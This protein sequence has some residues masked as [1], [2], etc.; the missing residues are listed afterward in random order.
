MPFSDEDLMRY[1]DEI[2]L[3]NDSLRAAKEITKPQMTIGADSLESKLRPIADKPKFKN[4]SFGVVIFK[5]DP[6]DK[7]KLKA[8]KV[9]FYKEDVAWQTD[10]TGKLAILLAGV[11]LRED[12]NAVLKAGDGLD[13]ASCDK[14]FSVIWKRMGNESYVT[15]IR[16]ED[17]PRISTIFKFTDRKADFFGAPGTD[18]EMWVDKLGNDE[19][20][21]NGIPVSQGEEL[22]FYDR[23]RL[24]G[25]F[26]NNV[27]SSACMSEIGIPY[28]VAVQKALGLYRPE[29]G[30]HLKIGGPFQGGNRVGRRVT[31]DGPYL[32]RD[33]I[34]EKHYKFN[35]PNYPVC[36]RQKD[37]VCESH[38]NSVQPGSVSA[39]LAFMI[40][41][42]EDTLVSKEACN[43]IR[44]CITNY[45]AIDNSYQWGIGDPILKRVPKPKEWYCKTG[46]IANSPSCSFSYSWIEEGII[47]LRSGVVA[48]GVWEG[49]D[50]DRMGDLG[51]EIYQAIK[52]EGI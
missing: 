48:M 41:L 9:W 38:K 36:I 19:I 15:E 22:L 11:Q 16:N 35:D 51:Y 33:N 37:D 6:I 34:S 43:T 49:D 13:P 30:M 25:R 10:S 12:V 50:P 32:F 4:I 24:I 3:L 20:G 8:T 40:A 17:A 18:R 44:D 7:N 14:L 5:E 27:I 31:K 28:M 29:V 39:L 46:Y 23:L 52:W 26:S 1:A 21:W 47:S 45:K 2:M 42:M